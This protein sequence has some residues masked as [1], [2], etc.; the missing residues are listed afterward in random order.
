MPSHLDV[1]RTTFSAREFTDDPV[2]DATLHRILDTARFAPSGGNRQGWRV[3]VVKD[4]GT[5]AALVELC[6]PVFAVYLAQMRAGER[7][8][9]TVTPTTIDVEAAAAEPLDLP[10]FDQLVRAPALLVIG[11]DLNQLAAMDKDLDRIGLV[12]GASIYPFVWNLLLAARAE[13]LAGTI[14]TFLAARETEAQAILG[15]P[16]HVAVAA[17]VPLGQP[18]TTLTKLR[19][20]PVESFATLDRYDGPPLTA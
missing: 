18:V 14:T 4:G 9:S 20:N 3:V 2:D 13:G 19:R 17:M 16:P 7:P 10:F 1:L 8:F 5:R 15:L 11:A 6:K 12:A